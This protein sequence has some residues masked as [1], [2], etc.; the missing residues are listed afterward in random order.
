VHGESGDYLLALAEGVI[1]PDHVRAELGEILAA[2]APGRATD[3]E[4][5]VFESLGLAVEDLAAAS[6]AYRKAADSGAGTWLDF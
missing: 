4:I 3:D 6:L 2:R 5:T 1:G